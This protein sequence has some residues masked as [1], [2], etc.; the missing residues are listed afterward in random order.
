MRAL[1]CLHN[2]CSCASFEWQR[3]FGLALVL[4]WFFF[5]AG[6]QGMGGANWKQEQAVNRHR[7][8]GGRGRKAVRDV[9]VDVLQGDERPSVVKGKPT[10]EQFLNRIREELLIRCYE[11]TS[12]S[13]YQSHIVALMRWHGGRPH[14]ISRDNVREYLTMLA[15][16]GA[17]SSKLSGALSA[18]RTVL[19][20]LCCRQVTFGFVIPRRSKKLPT[21]LS[22][23]EVQRLIDSCRSLRDKMLASLM[24]ATGLR[25]SEVASLGWCD[26]DFDRDCINVIRGKG[27][28]DRKVMLPETYRGLLKSLSDQAGAKG[29]IFPSEGVRKDRHLSVRTIQRRVKNAAEIA[30]ISKKVTPHSLRHAFATHLFEAGTNIRLIQSLLGHANL[31]TTCIYTHVADQVNTNTISP[32]DRLHQ[33]NGANDQN[34][35]DTRPGNGAPDSEVSRVKRAVDSLPEKPAVGQM[36]LH[37]AEPDEPGA[38]RDVVVEVLQDGAR[39]V[40][41]MQ[42]VMLHGVRVSMPRPGWVQLE[43]PTLER[44]APEL[45]KCSPA[46]QERVA[47]PE[48]C[49]ILQT[50]LARRLMME[51]QN[52]KEQAGREPRRD[53]IARG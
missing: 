11:R 9:V 34:S 33:S 19:D 45:A 48:F 24:Y 29:F 6:V 40:Q 14:Q 1:L 51:K 8:G 47:E 44:W 3:G 43:I 36:R 20:D 27:R 23:Q 21:I 38:A 10:T 46:I 5:L 25:V 31:E 53:E 30:G 16:T 7:S 15:E 26:V 39:N 49:Q 52:G 18:I 2:V 17:S 13:T 42:S 12:I 4:D 28:V 37:I 50:Q 41:S 35:S 32:L 22:M